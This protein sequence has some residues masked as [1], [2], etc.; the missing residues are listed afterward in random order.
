MKRRSFNIFCGLCLFLAAGVAVLWV[1]GNWVGDG[2]G[3]KHGS[4][5]TGVVASRG[6]L[7]FVSEGTLGPTTSPGSRW[8]YKRQGTKSFSDDIARHG[9]RGVLGFGI[10]WSARLVLIAV[11]DWSVLLLLSTPPAVWVG[12]RRRKRHG[13][14]FEVLVPES[15][16]PSG[17]S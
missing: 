8:V 15:K 13:R 7:A 12:S 3:Y 2:V 16:G 9:G 5:I 1:R 14:G 6:T 4:N 11:P 17:L 10:V